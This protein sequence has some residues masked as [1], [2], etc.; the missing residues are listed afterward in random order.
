MRRGDEA[1]DQH[2]SACAVVPLQ[3]HHAPIDQERGSAFD[4]RIDAVARYRTGHVVADA[5]NP[6]STYRMR[7][8]GRND[9]S[10]VRSRVAQANDG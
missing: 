5:S 4:D 10:A 9:F 3:G 7:G 1:G 6:E 8:G 2:A